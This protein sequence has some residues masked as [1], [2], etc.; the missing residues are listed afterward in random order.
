MESTLRNDTLL[1][2][3]TQ[4]RIVISFPQERINEIE[5]LAMAFPV[6]FSL[7]GKVGGS[8][9]TIMVNGNEIIKQEIDILKETWKTSLGNYA[10]QTT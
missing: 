4:S 2:G 5:D 3:E 9:L 10:G 1:F 7:I 8:H 6:D